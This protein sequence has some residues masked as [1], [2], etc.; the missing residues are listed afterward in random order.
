MGRPTWLGF[1]RRV[2]GRIVRRSSP[3]PAGHGLLFNSLEY[4]TFFL[5]VFV[6]YWATVRFAKVALSLLLV[7]SL[8]FYACWNPTYLL[9]IVASSLVDFTVGG[10]LGRTQDARKRRRLVLVSVVYN[11][12]VLSVF[13]YFNF[14][15][16][17]LD[18]AVQLVDAQTALTV[19][20]FYWP[21][22][23]MQ[24]LLPVGISFFT[25]QSMSYTIDIARRQLEPIDSYPRY[26]LFVS[27]FP[28]LV[29]GPIVRARDLLPQLAARPPLTDAMGG[30]GLYLVALGLFKKVVIAD[31]LAINLVDRTFAFP[32]QYSSFEMLCGVYGYAL[33]IYCDFSGYSDIAIGSALLLGFRFPDNFDAPYKSRDLQEFWRRWHISLSTWLRDYLY[34]ALGGNRRGPWR[35]YRNLML[36]MLLG[37]LWHGAGWNFIIWGALHGGALA[38][39]RAVQRWREAAGRQPLL[40]GPVGGVV[41]GLFTF[42]Y[43]CLAWIFFRATDLRAATDVLARLAEFTFSTHHLT[44]PVVAVMLVGVVTHLW[45]RAWFERIVA[46]FSTLPAAVQAAAL[47]A[48]GLGLQKAASA[49]V[50][51]FIYF[52][53]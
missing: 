30:R 26:L 11:L 37:G 7:A 22:F 5:V 48:V 47:V 25:F 20:E 3:R 9:L 40:R 16:G 50:V 49:D 32:G 44:A 13:K 38:V 51:P 45:P 53:F 15:M 10:R 1:T 17:A 31:F 24:V 35:T 36:T 42:H 2:G 28:Q 23:R 39:L 14:F 4:V 12:G 6:G 18:Q 43:V 27:F 34:I 41:A 29:A 46:G 33:Q 8:L 52:Q 21:G 19:G